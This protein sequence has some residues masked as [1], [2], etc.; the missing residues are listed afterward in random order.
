MALNAYTSALYITF[1]CQYICKGI[2]LSFFRSCQ[3]MDLEETFIKAVKLFFI[4]KH[5]LNV[6]Y[7]LWVQSFLA[8][9]NDYP[10]THNMTVSHW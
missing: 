8:F 1:S 10:V 5:F 6:K 9:C 4:S 7:V 2:N 3:Q